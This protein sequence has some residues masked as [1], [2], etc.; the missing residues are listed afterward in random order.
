VAVFDE[1]TAAHSA[2]LPV[3]GS[4]L[5]HDLALVLRCPW[6][7]AESVKCRVGAAYAD[8]S[9]NGQTVEIQ[10]F[11]TQTQ[12]DVAVSHVCEILQARTEELI[13][14]VGLELRRSGYLDRIAAGL[15]LTGGG[16]QLRGLAELA[17]ARLGIP[18]R[19]GHPRGY[20]GLTDLIGSPAYATAI[21]LVEYA[22]GD[23]ERAPA[24]AGARFEAPAGGIFRRLLS[25]GRALIPE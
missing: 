20:S 22:L 13:E 5:T 16:S 23:P 21:G 10:A 3:A 18:A 19:V 8:T 15:V 17:E 4:R 12:K 9:V 24:P 7:S 1:G 11:G 14:L 2:C 25:I 6:E